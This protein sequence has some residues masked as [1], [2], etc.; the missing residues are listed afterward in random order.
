MFWN[1]I[2]PTNANILIF[3]LN[4]IFLFNQFRNALELNSQNDSKLLENVVIIIVGY[5][6]APIEWYIRC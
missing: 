2:Y 6:K 3:M 4:I 1:I 5:N